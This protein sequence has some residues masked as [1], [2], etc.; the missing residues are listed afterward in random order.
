M[1]W[2]HVSAEPRSLLLAH[3]AGSQPCRVHHA[4]ENVTRSACPQAGVM[5]HHACSTQHSLSV[6]AA[7]CHGPVPE[8]LAE[9]DCPVG[10]LHEQPILRACNTV[11]QA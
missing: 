4:I 8:D 9:D 3:P 7:L 6:S 5:R 2:Y 10:K 1:V 11:Q